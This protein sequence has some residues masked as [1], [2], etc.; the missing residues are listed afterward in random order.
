MKYV[1]IVLL[2]I[3]LVFGFVTFSNAGNKTLTLGWG[4]VLPSPNDLAGWELYIANSVGGSATL[5]ATIPYTTTQTEY[6]TT[7]TV[8]VP[9]GTTSTRCFKILAFDTSGNKSGFSNEPCISLDFAS[10]NV[11]IT[12][13]ITVVPSP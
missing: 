12:L 3:L 4:Q 13:R 9:D 6:T 2:T 1:T 11:P 10:P 7:Q 5:F 8:T